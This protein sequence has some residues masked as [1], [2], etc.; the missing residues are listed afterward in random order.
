VRRAGRPEF[1]DDDVELIGAASGLFARAVRRGLV[2]EVSNAPASG[3][4]APGVIELDGAGGLLRMSSSAE[5][6]LAELS[7]SSGQAGVEHPAIHAVTSA[8]RSAVA[9]RAGDAGSVLPSSTVKTP[10]G[11]WLVLHGA[12]LG[13]ARSQTVA[14]FIQ[15]AHPTLVAPLLLKADGLTPRER[16]VAQL[17]LRGATTIQASVGWGSP[18]TPSPIT[19]SRFSR[20]SGR[21]LGGSCRR[22][23]FSA[24]TFPASRT[25]SPSAMTRRS[26]M[27]RARAVT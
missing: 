1:A 27:R 14:V 12:L 22:R 18:A 3:A 25:A 13:D 5:S 23:C 20:R 9:A 16:E 2:A 4:D 6:L 21:A 7:G 8:T 15:R 17:L 19:S 11:T 26:S 10:A 24:S